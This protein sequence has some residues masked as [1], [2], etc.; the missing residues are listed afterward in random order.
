MEKIPFSKPNINLNVLEDIKKIIKSGWLI[1]GK[2]TAEFEARFSKYIGVKH[3]VAA[4]SGTTALFLALKGLGIKEGDEVI[5]PSLTFVASANSIIHAGA[6]PVFAEIDKDTFNLSPE[7]VKEKITKRTKAVM[8]VHLYGQSCDMDEINEIAKKNDLKIIED[9]AQAIGALYKNRKTGSF[10]DAGCFSFHPIKNIT[11]GEGGLITTNDK[12]LY[13]KIKTLK[14]HGMVKASNG[15]GFAEIGYNFRLPEIN[16]AIGISQ[17]NDI[18][19]NNSLRVKKAGIYN[20]LLSGT[21]QIKIP[22]VRQ[23][24]KHVYSAYTI[25]CKDRDR[26]EQFLQSNN[27]QCLVRHP[28][29]HLEPVYGKMFGFKKGMLPVTESTAK[30]I[31]SLPMFPIL[32]EKD[33]QFI[34]SKIEEFWRK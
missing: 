31:L 12:G 21:S 24:N 27:I 32:P 6:K 30:E 34:S 13:E 15:R 16:A 26:L 17:M 25:K 7:S 1:E 3:A 29:V 33:I 9:S 14:N 23:Y 22:Y 4:S 5:V 2:Y 10:G 11:T 20:E 8:P 18:G 19:K 28:P